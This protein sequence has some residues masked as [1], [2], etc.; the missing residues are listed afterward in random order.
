M[1]ESKPC[2]LCG[3]DKAQMIGKVLESKEVYR[4]R[5]PMCNLI[6]FN[7]E[8]YPRPVYDEKYN[9]HFKRPGDIRKAG[10]MAAQIAEICEQHF[11][12]PGILEV[13]PANGLTA[14]LLTQM[15]FTTSVFDIDKRNALKIY[16]LLD[17]PAYMGDMETSL[18]KK[19]FHVIYSGHTIE[20][21]EN[22]LRFAKR[23]RESLRDSGV[24]FF[25]TPDAHYAQ[26]K[27]RYWK[28]FQT[29]DPFEHCCLFNINT[30]FKLAKMSGFKVVNVVTLAEFQSMQV[31]LQ[32]TGD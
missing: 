21:I 1:V 16:S 22:P 19:A 31:T 17:V 9:S 6:F 7:T 24:F 23:I 26:T 25:D 11:K 20:H 12:S 3:A 13:G 18:P 10:I 29:R 8:D 4:V 15:G 14:F 27:G 32:K 30:V 5:C 28:H 2:P